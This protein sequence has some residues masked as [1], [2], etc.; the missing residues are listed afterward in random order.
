M[1]NRRRLVA[2]ACW[3]AGLVMGATGL[4]LFLRDELD[5]VSLYLGMI[6]GAVAG[7]GIGHLLRTRPRRTGR[8][9]G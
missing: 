2:H 9:P 5:G 3:I 7:S 6:G 1:I 8:L 4:V